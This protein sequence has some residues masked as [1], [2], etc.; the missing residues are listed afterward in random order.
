[1][2][3]T[4]WALT[5]GSL[6]SANILLMAAFHDQF[7]T[8]GWFQFSVGRV[9]TRWSKVYKGCHPESPPAEGEYWVA[10][11]IHTL[12]KFTKAMWDNRNQI[13]HG[14]TSAEAA[15]ILLSTVQDKIKEHYETYCNMP[16]H[17]LP[18]H[19]QLFLQ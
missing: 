4:A 7:H 3:Q 14:A 2:P 18:R 1:L 5:F 15:S 16:G 12:W 10:L 17:V 9:S 11:L 8:I 13:I 19:E 6:C